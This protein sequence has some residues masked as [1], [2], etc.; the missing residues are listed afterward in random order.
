MSDDE[1]SFSDSNY[2]SEDEY[3]PTKKTKKTT[4]K[5]KKSA[6]TIDDYND[7]DNDVDNNEVLDD[8]DDDDDDDDG[9]DVGDDDDDDDGDDDGDD[10]VDVD[11]VDD[12]GDDDDDDDDDD[13]GMNDDEEY[14][15]ADTKKRTGKKKSQSTKQTNAAAKQDNYGMD[16]MD[17]NYNTD[18]DYNMDDDD[19]DDD[20]DDYD[21]NYL[22]KFDSETK[23][24]YIEEFHPECRE[25][26]YNE[27]MALS[28]V[29]RDEN[30][31]IIDPLHRTIPFLTKYERARVLGMRAKQI[32][33]GS[34]PF[35]EIPDNLFD[36]HIIA[37][38]ELEKKKMPFIIRRPLP[39]GAFE[40]W[41]LKDLECISY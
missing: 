13:I 30:N 21:E 3:L 12:V 33:Y 23:K 37:N 41:N 9:D 6:I 10:D 26:N 28:K 25:E 1:R 2:N 14:I 18:D 20:D 40:Y 32:E 17:S 4:I 27:I 39:N 24:N 22:Q 31:M 29:V 19:D 38:M 7:D 16:G 34:L 35:I 11:D 15:A 8:N 5:S 36:P